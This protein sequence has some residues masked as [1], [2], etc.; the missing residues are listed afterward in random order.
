MN[1]ADHMR[2]RRPIDFYAFC[3]ALTEP[4]QSRAGGGHP[5]NPGAVLVNRANADI[6]RR[7]VERYKIELAAVEMKETDLCAK[8]ESAVAVFGDVGHVRAGKARVGVEG[9][10]APIRKQ[11]H[12]GARADPQTAAR[13]GAQ[14]GDEIAVDLWS[15][16]AIKD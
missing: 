16:A 15:I 6:A 8:P 7:S 3:A 4:L 1:R 12:S 9:F 13:I 10:K 11:R 14:R 5:E 2:S